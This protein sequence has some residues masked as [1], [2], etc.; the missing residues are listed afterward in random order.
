MGRDVS[1]VSTHP[2]SLN[3]VIRSIVNADNAL[4]LSSGEIRY[5]IK[6]HKLFI[7]NKET[8]ERIYF[9]AR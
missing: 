8:E 3:P 7:F 4:D 1:V 5:N 2:A 6:P 9:Q